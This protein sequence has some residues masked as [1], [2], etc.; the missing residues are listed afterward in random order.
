MQRPPA[1]PNPPPVGNALV[2]VPSPYIYASSN[3]NRTINGGAQM[4]PSTSSPNNYP[5]NG[6]QVQKPYFVD[7]RLGPPALP[8]AW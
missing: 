5:Q 2:V 6:G 3:V 8:P 7:P 4:G 1:N